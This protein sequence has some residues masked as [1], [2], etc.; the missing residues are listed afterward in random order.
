MSDVV[1]KRYVIRCSTCKGSDVQVVGWVYPNDRGR[2]VIGDSFIE[3]FETA[4]EYGQTWCESCEGH[5]L[6]EEVEA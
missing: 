2:A 3:D 5:T 1:P 6:L 4:A